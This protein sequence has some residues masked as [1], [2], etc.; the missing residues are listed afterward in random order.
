MA[1]ASKKPTAAAGL[2]ERR[3]DKLMTAFE[4]NGVWPSSSGEVTFHPSHSISWTSWNSDSAPKHLNSSR[5]DGLPQPEPDLGTGS[6]KV[7]E[8]LVWPRRI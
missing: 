2:E 6:L 1:G 4:D 8:P 5:W 3:L 7:A